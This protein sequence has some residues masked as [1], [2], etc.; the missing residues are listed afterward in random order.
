MTPAPIHA[1]DIIGKYSQLYHSC[2]CSDCLFV[3]G[4]N[5][6]YLSNILL[7]WFLYPPI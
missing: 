5:I 1:P 4:F 2:T 6:V 3:L 7:W